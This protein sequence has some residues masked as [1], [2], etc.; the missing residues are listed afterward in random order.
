MQFLHSALLA[1]ASS[2]Y[3]NITQPTQQ[4]GTHPNN[5]A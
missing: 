5:I 2:M 3:L 4:T 1:K